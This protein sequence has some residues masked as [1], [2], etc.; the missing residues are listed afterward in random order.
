MD[1]PTR[2]P[3]LPADLETVNDKRNPTRVSGNDLRP[4]LRQS[5]EAVR[6]HIHSGFLNAG[7]ELVR[8]RPT[9][10]RGEWG[11]YLAA[12]GF[13]PGEV[14][15]RRAQRLMQATR[16]VDAGEVPPDLSLRATLEAV[17]KK[18][19]SKPAPAPKPTEYRP[20]GPVLDRAAVDAEVQRLLD[21]G[22]ESGNGALAHLALLT[23][24][25]RQ[26]GRLPSRRWWDDD[27]C[28][29]CDCP[30]REEL[31]EAKLAGRYDGDPWHCPKGD[32][33]WRC[34]AEGAADA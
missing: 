16:A 32:R 25:V 22:M 23:V 3:N 7:R 18:R 17:A 9:M 34:E 5:A 19:E 4:E 14:G 20:T 21:E 11:P 13:D 31:T 29:Y 30:S 8:I 10:R 24:H 12:C 1:D 2:S 6:A 15:V 27:P 28:S 33:R 26:T